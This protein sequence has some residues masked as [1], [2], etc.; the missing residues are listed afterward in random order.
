MKLVATIASG[1]TG[2]SAAV[3]LGGPD[4]GTALVAIQMPATW[5][6]A[7]L[8]F[9]AG[10]T[11]SGTFYNVYAADGTEVVVTA[12]TSRWIILDPADFA[13]VVWI[14]VRSGTAATPVDQTATRTINL[15]TRLV[16]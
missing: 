10:E 2:L 5:V 4:R 16:S 1:A 6:A 8:T 11:Q 7:N 15:I 9:Q 12:S 13:S 14:K 3:H